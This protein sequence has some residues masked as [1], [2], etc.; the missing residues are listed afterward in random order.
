MGAVRRR[1]EAHPAVDV[2]LL[3]AAQDPSAL[4]AAL[5]PDEVARARH[6]GGPAGGRFIL[7]RGLLR[8]V[9]AEVSGLPASG[10]VLSARC[11]VC[12]GPHGPVTVHRPDDPARHVSITRSGPL[13][14]VALS[15]SGPVGVDVESA[16]AVHRSPVDAVLLAPSDRAARRGLA[17]AAAEHHLAALWVRKEAVLKAAGVG[18]RTPPAQ[19]ELHHD[20]VRLHGLTIDVADLPVPAGLHA[21]VAL[22]RAGT[23]RWAHERLRARHVTL[24][25]GSVVLARHLPT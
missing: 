19:L 18:L 23:G 1:R 13:I 17:P 24:H 6:L 4:A 12:G 2:W 9:L 14:A 22:A 8:A 20:R 10:V 25:D 15:G 5:G 16:L 21:A 3:D 11:P 7:A